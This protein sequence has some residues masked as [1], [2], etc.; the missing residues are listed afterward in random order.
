MGLLGF[1]L[2]S[3]VKLAKLLSLLK[4]GSC[5][6]MIFISNLYIKFFQQYNIG[7]AYKHDNFDSLSKSVNFKEFSML[8]Q[9]NWSGFIQIIIDF[10]YIL[11]RGNR[12]C[13]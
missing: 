3:P 7:G 1:S 12:F 13:F 5:K 2:F 10:Y 8:D 11:L 6:K 4:V 9:S